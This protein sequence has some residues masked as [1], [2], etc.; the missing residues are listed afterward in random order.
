MYKIKN[1]ILEVEINSELYNKAVYQASLLPYETHNAIFTGEE[2]KKR[3]IVGALGEVAFEH[4]FQDVIRDNCYDYDFIYEGM[5]VDIKTKLCNYLPKVEYEL[6]ILKYLKN[7]QKCDLYVFT[8]VNSEL[9]KVELLGCISKYR[10]FKDSI[11]HKKG[12]IDT[13]NNYTF[14]KDCYNLKL[15]Q[16]SPIID[17]LNYKKKV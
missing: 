8:R 11:F 9:N 10:Y 2:A 3:S 16:L 4:V 1:N 13:S 14:K 7:I 5:K 6:S 15:S 12:E 17:L